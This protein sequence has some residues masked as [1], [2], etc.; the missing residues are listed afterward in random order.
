M[1]T[2]L[3]AQ[4]IASEVFF[5]V[6]EDYFFKLTVKGHRYVFDHLIMGGLS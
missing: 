4:L 1:A 3:K 5:T 2:S 6:D